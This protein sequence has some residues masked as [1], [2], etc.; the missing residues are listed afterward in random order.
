[1]LTNQVVSIIKGSLPPPQPHF[2]QLGISLK[3]ELFSTLIR[4][5]FFST[6]TAFMVFH[7]PVQFLLI[8]SMPSIFF[9]L[10]LQKNSNIFLQIS[11]R[12]HIYQPH[13]WQLSTSL[14]TELFSTLIRHCF[15]STVTA[16]MVFHSPVQFLLIISMP[17][18]FFSSSSIEKQ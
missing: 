17:S 10:P 12:I 16:F 13:F 11:L 8:I 15:F 3:T 1:M 4:H 14:K 2:Q 18:I 6:V 7:S 9:P 5:C